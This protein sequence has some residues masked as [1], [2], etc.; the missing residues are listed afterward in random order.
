M[1]LVQK[2][3]T[4]RLLALHAIKEVVSNCS[5]GQLETVAEVVWTPLFEN[6]DNAEEA[7]RNV[8]SASLGKLAAINPSRYLGQLRAK[9]QDPSAAVRATVLSAMRYTLADISSEYDDQLSPLVPEF[10][11]LMNDQDLVRDFADHS[12]SSC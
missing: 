11:S 8:A 6:S 4:R 5:H 2:D 7:T 10:L 12:V 3:A 1:Q 9:L